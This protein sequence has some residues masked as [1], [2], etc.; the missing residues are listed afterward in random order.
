MVGGTLRQR[1]NINWSN[2]IFTSDT[3]AWNHKPTGTK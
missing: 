3:N 1:I 2:E